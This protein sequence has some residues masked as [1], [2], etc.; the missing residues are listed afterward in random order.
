[1]SADPSS[2]PPPARPAQGGDG[3]AAAGRRPRLARL[4]AIAM[5][6][7]ALVGGG[8]VVWLTQRLKKL[9][10]DY[11]LVDERGVSMAQKARELGAQLQQVA[12]EKQRVEQDRD[13]LLSQVK[14]AQEKQEEAEGV[15]NL[16]EKVLQRT[17]EEHRM[18]SERLPVM[19]QELEALQKERDQLAKE[20]ADLE[21][22][23]SRR[24]NKTDEK[25]LKEQLTA[26]RKKEDEL[27]Q[28]LGAAR[29]ELAQATLKAKR[30]E[31]ERA[32]LSTRLDQL[33]QEYTQEVTTN[34]SLRR[35]VERLPK[36]VT[37]IAREHER[38]LQEL[39]DTHYNMGVMFSERGDYVRAAK[40]FAQV[41]E[42]RPEDPDAQYNLGI[43]YAEYLPD[44]EKALRFF[45]RYL[46]G[47][48]KGREASFAKQY[49][50]SW[51]AWEGKE[52]LE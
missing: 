41:I 45:H 47:N 46:A 4:V 36:D 32:R 3:S 9:Q 15:R 34:A 18:M 7:V 33:Q 31:E 13:N 17:G 22:R 44:R 10:Y 52:R 48:P 5:A 50:A 8:G 38:L 25:R 16:L 35:Q 14:L 21:D 28:G 23:L 29:R 11:A 30:L 49:I 43:I 27:E 1:M 26:V 12:G 24:Q 51:R 42:V 20:H 2:M 40:E 37:S 39:A 6:G 19:E